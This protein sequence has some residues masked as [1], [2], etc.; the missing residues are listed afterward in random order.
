MADWLPG[1]RLR[2]RYTQSLGWLPIR[3]PENIVLEVQ[4]RVAV[5][6]DL[7]Q[8]LHHVWRE[9]DAALDKAQEGVASDPQVLGSR[10]D[11]QRLFRVGGQGSP[12][13]LRARVW[14]HRSG[15]SE[16]HQVTGI[17]TRR[18]R[19]WIWSSV[20]WNILPSELL[21]LLRERAVPGL[22][23]D[24]VDEGNAGEP[25]CR[26]KSLTCYADREE[27]TARRTLIAIRTVRDLAGQSSRAVGTPKFGVGDPFPR[28]P[29]KAVVPAE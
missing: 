12:N 4:F 2:P 26:R 29:A 13:S 18:A 25:D 22:A 11:V 8:A 23:G 28:S 20:G 15:G 17:C 10:G 5:E 24:R 9:G 14:V 27:K 1:Y 21:D 7:D 19:R 6:E 16:G 3:W